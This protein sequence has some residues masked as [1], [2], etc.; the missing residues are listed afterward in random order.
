MNEFSSFLGAVK[1]SE[2]TD[3]YLILAALYCLGAHTQPITASQI[4]SLLKLHLGSNTP[5]NVSASLRKYEGLVAP[6][7]N[8]SPIPWS[9][10]PLGLSRLRL[11]S[12]LQLK[13]EADS[14]EF[15]TDIGIICALE[16][17]ELAAVIN[18]FSET[19]WKELPNPQYTHVYRESSIKTKEGVSLRVIATTSTSMGLTAAAIAT[20]Q[21]IM[22][23]KPRIV[24][25]IGIAAGTRSGGKEFG[26]ILTA[27]PSI[28]YNSGKVVDEDGIRGFQPD[29]YPIGLNPR[30]RSVLARYRGNHS[31]FDKIRS[32]WN[33]TPPPKSNHLHVG[34][35]GAADQVID[36]ATRII[37][38]QKNWRK[39]IG[40][41]METY[42]VY[43][44]VHEAP[45]PKPRVVSFKSVCDF[46]AEKTDS[47][48]E[49]AAFTA[50][51]FAFQFLKNEW[52]AL[53]PNKIETS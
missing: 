12:G 13:S 46:A 25:M 22:Q 41:E 51:E 31:I 2:R 32:R 24:V 21:L 43:R 45:E 35:L 28:D 37:E 17:P 11:L 27:D 36:D 47:W 3:Q 1:K 26:D 19:E 49:Y 8:G 23:F 18:T 7:H 40:V 5:S 30:L 4:T 52:T 6:T 39:L 14:K 50:A 34:P 16:F 20:T 15:E 29:P 38:I 53:W 42:G 10:T 33:G 9:L 48:Q 44:A